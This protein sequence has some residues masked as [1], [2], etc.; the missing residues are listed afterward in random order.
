MTTT[1]S[2]QQ[3]M[4]RAIGAKNDESGSRT[5]TRTRTHTHSQILSRTN[6]IRSLSEE[7]I[8]FNKISRI[9]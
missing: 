8:Y 1:L 3:E 4:T 6:Q 7:E 9:E 2:R 5:R